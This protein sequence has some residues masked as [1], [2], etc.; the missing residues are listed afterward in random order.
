MEGINSNQRT[1]YIT[2]TYKQRIKKTHPLYELFTDITIKSKNLYNLALYTERQYYFEHKKIIPRF[3]LQT[4]LKETDAFKQLPSKASQMITHQVYQTMNSFLRATKEYYKNPSKFLGKP[5][6]PGYKDKTTGRNIVTI[7][8]HTFLKQLQYKC[9]EAGI[10]LLEVEESYT[11]GTSFLD[12]EL[13]IKENYNKTRRKYRGLFV[14]SKGFKINSD[15]N[16]AYQIL[17]KVPAFA[18]YI[19]S[20]PTLEY[21]PI[22]I[23]VA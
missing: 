14:T 12:N 8:Y 2:K 5:R 13:P 10:H 19:Q 18:P 21:N 20:L 1:I 16:A 15:I 17:K 11:S 7:P 9:I 23:N 22:K 3:T 6:I 4:M